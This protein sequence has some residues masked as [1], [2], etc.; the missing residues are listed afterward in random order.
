MSARDLIWQL[1]SIRHKR[2]ITQ[3]ALAARMGISRPAVSRLES[4][5][6]RSPLL[7][8]VLRYCDALDLTLTPKPKDQT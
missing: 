4:E 5:Q 1:A 6:D 7:S 3:A 8:T 2:G